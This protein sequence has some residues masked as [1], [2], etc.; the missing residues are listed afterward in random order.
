MSEQ[1]AGGARIPARRDITLRP[2]R[3]SL[4]LVCAERRLFLVREESRWAD[5]NTL[6]DR[7]YP[8]STTRGL[9]YGTGSA[10]TSQ[11]SIG[12]F[13]GRFRRNCRCRP[14]SRGAD[15]EKIWQSR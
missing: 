2:R 11:R 3:E 15:K 4:Q 13:L 1:C 8:A 12:K 9:R 7:E 14:Q 5:Y 10:T 6:S